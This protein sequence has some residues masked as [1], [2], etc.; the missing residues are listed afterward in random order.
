MLYKLEVLETRRIAE[1]AG[2]LQSVR[3]RLL[4]KV[5]ETRL[6]EPPPARG[7]HDWLRETLQD[8]FAALRPLSQ[9]VGGGPAPATTLYAG[10]RTVPG[11]PA[12]CT[13]RSESGASSSDRTGGLQAISP[14]PLH[15]CSDRPVSEATA[16]AALSGAPSAPGCGRPGRPAGVG[17][18]LRLLLRGRPVPVDRRRAV[19]EPGHQGS[20]QWR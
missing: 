17:P 2:D 19:L 20:S 3:D 7:E 9:V 5:P 15:R 13:Q 4:E 10:R 14:G 18:V 11:L 8:R 6:G 16:F 12:A 1:L